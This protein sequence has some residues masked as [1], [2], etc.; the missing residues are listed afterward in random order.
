MNNHLETVC[1]IVVTYNRKNLLIECLEALRRQIRP[2]DSIYLVDNASIDGTTELLNEKAYLNEIPPKYL[3]EPWEKEFNIKNLTNCND[4]VIHYVRMNENTGGAG[5]FYEGL[6]RGFEKGY[7]WMW[8]MDDDAEPQE[9]AL[10]ELCKYFEISDV[11]ALAGVVYDMSR[12][13]SLYHR[14]FIKFKNI[15]PMMQY[16]VQIELYDNDIVEIDMASFVGILVRKESIQAVGYPMKEFFIHHDDVE[17]CIRLRRVGRILL[18]TDSIILHKDQYKERYSQKSFFR[19]RLARISYDKYWLSY[20]GIRNLVWLGKNYSISKLL[21]Y[22]GLFKNY[23]LNIIDI[24][25]WDDNKAKRIIFIT[26][27]YADGLRGSFD[28]KKPKKILYGTP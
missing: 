27:A 28:N 4:I 17:Y 16:P 1:A 25:L 6:K 24:L 5:G 15:F 18:V 19:K 13:I 26:N 23:T 7:D 10:A 20:Y 12:K 11:S 3:I 22:A 21:F 9:D 14:G 8:L 2:I